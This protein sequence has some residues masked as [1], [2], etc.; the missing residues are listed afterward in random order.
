LLLG[1][2]LQHIITI[3]ASPIPLPLA[4]RGRVE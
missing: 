3:A 2:L 1:R 4:G